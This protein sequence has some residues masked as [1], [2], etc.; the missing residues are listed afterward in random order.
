MRHI[1]HK[2]RKWYIEQVTITEQNA[3]IGMHT[4]FLSLLLSSLTFRL[5]NHIPTIHSYPKHS[6]IQTRNFKQTC[7]FYWI[8]FSSSP[9]YFVSKTKLIFKMKNSNIWCFHLVASQY[10]FGLTCYS[11]EDCGDPFDVASASNITV[12]GTNLYCKVIR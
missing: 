6:V 4:Y 11:C 7:M 9:S 10:A 3:Q 2:A 12:N 8:L 1:L 5:N